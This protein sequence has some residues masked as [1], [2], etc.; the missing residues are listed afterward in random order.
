MGNKFETDSPEGRGHI[1]RELSAEEM[2]TD[3]VSIPMSNKL[4]M[5]K[6]EIE[7]PGLPERWKPVA[8][9]LPKDTD[10]VLCCG[11]VREAREINP[12]YE[13]LIVEKIKPKR[14]TFEQISNTPRILEMGE[15]FRDEDGCLRNVVT[16]KS[17]NKY[18]PWKLVEEE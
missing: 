13:W 15:Y 14:V 5:N 3:F 16:E 1:R 4:P 2:N 17:F 7:I 9:R 12:N 8:Y 11:V 6:F 18:L 10:T